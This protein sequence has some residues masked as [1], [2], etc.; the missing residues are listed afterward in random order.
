MR[1]SRGRATSRRLSR[2]AF[3]VCCSSSW[4]GSAA[5]EAT[6]DDG[7]GVLVER[8]TRADGLPLRR[9]GEHRGEHRLGALLLLRGCRFERGDALGRHRGRVL[10]LREPP[11]RIGGGG[12]VA[13][14][15]LAGGV[16]AVDL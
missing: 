2:G 8:D 16:V 4:T 6:P 14:H 12:L 10:V 15:L 13:L 9:R 1:R 11:P 5:A 7:R 3:A